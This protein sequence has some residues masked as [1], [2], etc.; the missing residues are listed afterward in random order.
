MCCGTST[1]EF[2]SPSLGSLLHF[3]LEV[4]SGS[5]AQSEWQRARLTA[6]LNLLRQQ[7]ASCLLPQSIFHARLLRDVR[8]MKRSMFYEGDEF[9]PVVLATKLSIVGYRVHIRS[10][11]G[12]NAGSTDCF[13]NLRNEFLVVA[14]EGND[15]GTH[16]IVESRFKEHFAIPHPT[17]RYQGLLEAVPSEI[18]AP[19]A[20]LAPLVNLLCSEMSL[21][22]RERGLSLPPWRQGKS[23]LS[24]WLPAKAKDM[25]MSTPSTS[26]R[27]SSPE[28][29]GN[30]TLSALSSGML[31]PS[32]LLDEDSPRAVLHGVAAALRSAP[33]SGARPKMQRSLLSADLA[34]SGCT[35]PMAHGKSEN[36][37]S[38]GW[39]T[40]PI[41][42]VRMSGVMGKAF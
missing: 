19:P 35:S 16:F 18:A 39:D 11:L 28:G 32:G 17:E 29:P 4:E 8:A 21:A 20:A 30:L 38:T 6:Q 23:L 12:G 26:P 13:F 24:K 27:A 7:V 40:P 31:T 5:E 1:N 3:D 36:N 15:A 42:R 10:A 25:D 33:T 22:F 41:R 34:A 2:A 9:D 14:G 37:G